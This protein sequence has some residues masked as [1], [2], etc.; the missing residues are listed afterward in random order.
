MFYINKTKIKSDKNLYYKSNNTSDSLELIVKYIEKSTDFKDNEVKT[1][2]ALKSIL[3]IENIE[4]FKV[5]LIVKEFYNV[6]KSTF[7][8]SSFKLIDRHINKINNSKYNTYKNI[9]EYTFII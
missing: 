8:K 5:S 2:K 4:R 1:L 9:N 6:I 3:S 7:N